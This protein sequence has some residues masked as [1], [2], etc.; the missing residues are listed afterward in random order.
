[1]Y[2][3]VGRTLALDRSLNGWNA[4]AV[5]TTSIGAPFF[6]SREAPTFWW[7]HFCLSRWIQLARL[8]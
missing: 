3:L 4:C 6:A 2:C 1:V 5:T 8:E 7:A